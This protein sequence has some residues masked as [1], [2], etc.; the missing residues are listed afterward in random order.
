MCIVVKNSSQQS[1][2]TYQIPSLTPRFL[3][4]ITG[5]IIIRAILEGSEAQGH[6]PV[7]GLAQ[8]KLHFKEGLIINIFIGPF[9]MFK[10]KNFEIEF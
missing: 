3:C 2:Y 4:V 5:I 6:S 8:D 9:G 7:V 10:K 1:L